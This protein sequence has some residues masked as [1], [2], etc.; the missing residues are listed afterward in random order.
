VS[1]GGSGTFNTCTTTLP[2]NGGLDT[3]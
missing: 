3:D 1:F 2:T